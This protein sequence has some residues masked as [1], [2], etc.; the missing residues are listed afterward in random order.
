MGEVGVAPEGQYRGILSFSA[1]T[2]TR[3]ENGCYFI[4]DIEPQVSSLTL[5]TI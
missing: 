4:A 3:I 5:F 2:W 1:T